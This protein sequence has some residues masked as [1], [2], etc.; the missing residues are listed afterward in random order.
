VYA[1]SYACL[2]PLPLPSLVPVYFSGS[3]TR[4][5]VSSFFFPVFFLSFPVFSF[6]LAACRVSMLRGAVLL[7]RA[8]G[9]RACFSCVRRTCVGQ[10]TSRCGMRGVGHARGEET[11]A[12]ARTVAATM[13]GAGRR[14][15][16]VPFGNASPCAHLIFGPGYFALF[17]FPLLSTESAFSPPGFCRSGCARSSRTCV[18]ICGV[19]GLGAAAE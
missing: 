12:W 9:W 3:A 14:Y 2:R 4:R 17:L 13:A 10:T 19:L 16:R 6:V 5:P 15:S 11:R 7:G 18:L 8:Q 1:G